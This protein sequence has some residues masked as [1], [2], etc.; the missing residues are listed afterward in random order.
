MRNG[1]DHIGSQSQKFVFESRCQQ[2]ICVVRIRDVA[3]CVAHAII[4]LR[5]DGQPVTAGAQPFVGR[6]D[7][8]GE[9]VQG[10]CRQKRRDIFKRLLSDVSSPEKAGKRVFLVGLGEKQQRFCEARR[11]AKGVEHGTHGLDVRHHKRGFGVVKVGELYFDSVF[12]PAQAQG[13]FWI[14][15]QVRPQGGMVQAGVVKGAQEWC[16]FFLALR[17][18]Q[19]LVRAQDGFGEVQDWIETRPTVG[20]IIFADSEAG[21]QESARHVLEHV[22]QVRRYGAQTISTGDF[23]T[24]G[25]HGAPFLGAGTQT[26]RVDF[27]RDVGCCACSRDV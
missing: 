7:P 15:Q 20:H 13:L 6:H 17:E 16:E 10:V 23:G 5:I 11:S 2:R 21:V 27:A 22:V 12:F 24:C 18:T 26:V 1:E 3:L 8:G 19:L 4:G 25:C 14:A 9:R